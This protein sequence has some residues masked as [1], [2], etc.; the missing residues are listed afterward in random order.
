[1]TYYEDY[2][3]KA[4]KEKI[5]YWD[6]IFSSEVENYNEKGLLELLK[7]IILSKDEKVFCKMRALQEMVNLTLIERIKER[8]TIAFLLDDWEDIDDSML[9]CSRLKYIS[10]FY[11]KEKDEIK[12]IIGDKIHDENEV[13]KAEANYQLALIL[14][15]DSNDEFN[16]NDYIKAITE[17]QNLFENVIKTEGN[18]VDAE[19]LS[20]VCRYIKSSLVSNIIE[21]SLLYEKI[22]YLIWE[23]ILLH[24]DDEANPIYINIGRNITKIHLLLTRNPDEWIDYKKEFN[25]LCLDF[26]DLTNLSY[27]N[28][29]F[30][31]NLIN[32]IQ[33]KL[34]KEVI[35]PVFKY[36]FRATLSKI[37]V[38]L[39]RND[40]NETD[41]QFLYYLR[42]II[43]SE[44]VE[45]IDIG[46]E[47]LKQNFP[48]LTEDDIEMTK[49]SISQSNVSGA[50]NYLLEAMEK[51]SP[52]RLLNDIIC[53][54][55]RLQG[56]FHY[57]NVTE[58]ERND[59]IRDLLETKGYS[60]KDQTRQGTSKEGKASGEVDILIQEKDIPYAIIEALNLSSLN[61]SYLD[62]HIDK[63][64]KY[65][66]LGYDCNFIISY[67]TIKDFNVFWNKYKNHI[68]KH[69][70]PY[71]LCEYDESIN[72]EFNFSEIK[73]ALT[74]HNRN[75]KITLLYHICAKMQD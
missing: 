46:L 4:L 23:V 9:E 22:N 5:K 40:I 11:I 59:F 26:Y 56:N 55:I 6:I 3:K 43:E 63:I 10:L 19:L 68:Q 33:G 37:N 54:C 69:K 53:A 21:S 44:D 24:L 67:V 52:D 45:R 64:Y 57:K 1:M 29:N 27:K 38:I 17:A 61:A 28:N 34:H 14:L 30:Y 50:I 41:R 47:V 2:C 32:R 16:K 15:F 12:K 60:V 51:Y 49:K 13:V 7:N 25:K 8:K 65:D 35:E 48:M 74:K 70:Y 72:D 42:D 62:I 31:N 73:V 20:L 39:G 75:G 71:E 18:R 58:D 36:N 66:T